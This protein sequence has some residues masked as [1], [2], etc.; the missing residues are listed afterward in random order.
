M[1]RW[2][3][4]WAGS[5]LAGCGLASAAPMKASPAAADLR[6]DWCFFEQEGFGRVVPEKV[7]IQLSE[8]GRYRWIEGGFQQRGHWRLREGQLEMSQIGRH[9]ILDQ[10]AQVLSLRR[11]GTTM[12]LHRGPCAPA[13]FS[14]QDRVAFHN[15][16]STGDLAT[17]EQFLD[18]GMPPDEQDHSR[19]DTALIKAA[20]FCR[21][22]IARHLL[23]RGAQVQIR[24]EEGKLALDYARSSSFHRGCEVLVQML[25]P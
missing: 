15:A 11:M 4:A 2:V 8:D 20:K 7:Q 24:N 19:A 17:L 14:S 16:A 5:L 9:E 12:K 1:K 10:S 13:S 22:E 3:A 25:G 23:A 6:G 21:P 18:R